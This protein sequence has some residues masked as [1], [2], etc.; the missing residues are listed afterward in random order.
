MSTI[1]L[2]SKGCGTCQITVKNVS[3]TT[4]DGRAVLV[5][6]P[7]AKPPAGVV[8]KQWVVIDGPAQ[9]HFAIDQEEV[10]S[11]KI[12]V[13]QKKGEPAPAGN[14]SF[15]LDVV[16]VAQP[17]ESGDQSQALGFTMSAVAAPPARSKTLLIGI[18]AAVVLI[19][20]GVTTWLLL[21]NSNAKPAPTATATPPPAA[22][23]APT[24]KPIII[25]TKPILP[26]LALSNIRPAVAVIAVPSQPGAKPNT[27]PFA[28]VW[29]NDDTRVKDNGFEARITQVG[30]AVSLKSCDPTRC[31]DV[32][33][34]GQVTGNNTAIFN[35]GDERAR[36]QIDSPGHMVCFGELQQSPGVWVAVTK[37]SYH[38]VG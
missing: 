14:Y 24:A 7:V 1:K 30:N 37:V 17:D 34:K 25:A 5:S 31:F 35:F 13:L 8:E 2:D 38:K 10:F 26:T 6:L 22:S 16:N 27:S 19:V 23:P 4:L 9:R 12:A 33:E 3:G 20:G 32:I 21:R 15:R 28:G 29:D 18:I 36:Y 11:V